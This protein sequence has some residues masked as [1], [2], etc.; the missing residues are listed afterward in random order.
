MYKYGFDYV[1]RY[2]YGLF[3]IDYAAPCF[4][5]FVDDKN[6]N[7]ILEEN[8]PIILISVGRDRIFQVGQKEEME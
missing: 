8:E 4:T 1:H 5:L 2:N 7:Q 6:S 3:E